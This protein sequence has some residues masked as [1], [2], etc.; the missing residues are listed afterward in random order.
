VSVPLSDS[1]EKI[2]Q[3]LNEAVIVFTLD[4]AGS[5][6]LYRASLVTPDQAVWALRRMADSIEAEAA[7]NNPVS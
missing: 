4:A 1:M 3:H 5:G 7:D 6:N 2:S